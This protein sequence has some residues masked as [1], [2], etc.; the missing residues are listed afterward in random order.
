MAAFTVAVK[1]A[2]VSQVFGFIIKCSSFQCGLL[3]GDSQLFDFLYM[4]K[5]LGDFSKRLKAQAA[6]QSIKLVM[7]E[8]LK[9]VDFNSLDH[10]KRNFSSLCKFP[11]RQTF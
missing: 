4:V 3:L 10:G 11:L 2:I 8:I 1:P 6:A 5:K 9:R 7:S